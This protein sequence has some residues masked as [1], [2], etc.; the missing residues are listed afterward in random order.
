[1]SER[2]TI[3]DRH[4]QSRVEFDPA[5]KAHL[6]ELRFFMANGKWQDG[7]PFL[8][9]HPYLEIPT[10]CYQRLAEHSLA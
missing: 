6:K 2:Q 4:R 3:L 9:E 1:M 10:M 8:L 7:C 5:N